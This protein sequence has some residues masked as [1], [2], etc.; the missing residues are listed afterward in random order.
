MGKQPVVLISHAG[1]H[2]PVHYRP[3][4]KDLREKGFIV[5]VPPLPTAAHD[6]SLI[7]KSTSHDVA[8]IHEVLVPYLDAGHKAII[9]AHSSGGIAGTV[10]IKDQTV[11]ERAARGLEGGIVSIIWLAAV[12]PWESGV[13][14]LDA[15]G[16]EWRGVEWYEI[17][18]RTQRGSHPQQ[19]IDTIILSQ[20]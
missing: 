3:L 15:A 5:L 10:A 8:R 11:A 16:G 9:F 2:R 19:M 18:V 1:W 12:V 7:G 20:C 4:I 17:G 14:L 6:D 13:S